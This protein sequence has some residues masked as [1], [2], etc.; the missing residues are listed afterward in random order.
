MIC[1]QNHEILNTVFNISHL[2]VLHIHQRYLAFFFFV[3]QAA[4]GSYVDHFWH[5][6]G[7]SVNIQGQSGNIQE[8]QVYNAWTC[9]NVQKYLN[10]SN[11][12]HDW[13]TFLMG[14]ILPHL[15]DN[16]YSEFTDWVWLLELVQTELSIKVE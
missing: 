15:L 8:R 12:K 11:S 9:I 16:F 3:I 7:Q 13:K 5:I 10:K 2:F 6:Q 14:C 4:V 1:W